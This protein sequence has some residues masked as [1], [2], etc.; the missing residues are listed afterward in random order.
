MP[1]I[2]LIHVLFVRHKFNYIVDFSNIFEKHKYAII[3]CI[4]ILYN[5][6]LTDN[7]YVLLSIKL[8][9]TYIFDYMLL[10]YYEL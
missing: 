10:Y 7:Y 9:S 5:D 3:Y 1:H 8:I 6:A 4:S 2:Y